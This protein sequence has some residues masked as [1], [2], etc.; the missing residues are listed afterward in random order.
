MPS[1]VESPGELL[2]EI[3]EVWDFEGVVRDHLFQFLNRGNPPS[4]NLCHLLRFNDLPFPEQCDQLRRVLQL[5][6]TN[7]LGYLPE[8]IK[9]Q[10]VNTRFQN[11]LSLFVLPDQVIS[12]RRLNELVDHTTRPLV[13]GPLGGLEKISIYWRFLKLAKVVVAS[14]L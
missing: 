4:R 7:F 13:L 9:L 10:E 11:I 1:R 6:L 2:K 14:L 8:G 5:G 12:D 3:M